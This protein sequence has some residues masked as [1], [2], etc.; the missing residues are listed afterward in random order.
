VPEHTL[1]VVD[2][3]VVVRRSISRVFGNEGF[4]VSEAA[5]LREGL[6]LFRAS[7]PDAALA[8]TRVMGVSGPKMT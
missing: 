4:R 8:A 3:E 2:D 6:E 5:S 1:L 7:P